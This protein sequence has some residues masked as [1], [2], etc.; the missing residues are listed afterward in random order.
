VTRL[1]ERSAAGSITPLVVPGQTQVVDSSPAA[2]T[3]LSDL[4]VNGAGELFVQG[5]TAAGG[6]LFRV[7]PPLRTAEPARLMPIVRQGQA[8]PRPPSTAK[9]PGLAFDG[10]FT[11]SPESACGPLYFTAN[12]WKPGNGGSRTQGFFRRNAQGAVETLLVASLVV[13]GARDLVVSVVTPT[14]QACDRPL[15]TLS[16]SQNQTVVTDTFAFATR[17]GDD[18]WAIYRARLLRDPATGRTTLSAVLVAR[19]GQQL[20]DGTG[21]ISLDPSILLGRPVNSGPVFTV[22][23]AG[24]VAFLATDGRRW[25]IYRF[26]D[27]S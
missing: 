27:R 9:D 20:P 14:D 12:V 5:A 1:F 19:E 16:L 17:G 18:R 21:L 23:A 13:S 3:D 4:V 25:S 22:N 10:S 6:G 15:S 2:L 11:L 26:S 8:I 7:E 24:D